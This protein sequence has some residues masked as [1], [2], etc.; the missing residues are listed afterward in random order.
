MRNNGDFFGVHCTPIT[1]FNYQTSI[2]FFSRI[3]KCILI[4]H[5]GIEKKK[6]IISIPQSQHHWTLRLPLKRLRFLVSGLPRRSGTWTTDLQNVQRFYRK[7]IFDV[8]IQGWRAGAGR[9]RVFLAP[10]SWSRLKKTRSRSHLE[11]KSGAGAGAAK[12]LAGSSALRE[13]KKHR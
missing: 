8:L 6:L 7:M 11:K 10:W 12:K 2:F 4:K 1:S 9:S 3:L 13:D 5:W